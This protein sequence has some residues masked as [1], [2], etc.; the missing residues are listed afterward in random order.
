MQYT[1]IMSPG[2][3]T[4]VAPCGQVV[5]TAARNLV[6]TVPAIQGAIEAITKAGGRV[7]NVSGVVI[8]GT[9]DELL[10]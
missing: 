8:A 6:T 2:T 9:L 4:L 3:Q 1:L 7:V 10:A 5:V